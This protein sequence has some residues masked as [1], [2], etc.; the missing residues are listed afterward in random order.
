[1]VILDDMKTAISIPDEIFKKAERTA[2]KLGIS[3]SELYA[4][5]VAEF[6]QVYGQRDVTRRLDEVYGEDGSSL[7]LVMVDLQ[8]RSLDQ[9]DW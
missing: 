3:R 4:R 8:A 5:A 1:M 2:R 9:E 7:D 6:V